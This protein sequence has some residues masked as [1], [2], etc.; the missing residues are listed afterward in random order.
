[1]RIIA[2]SAFES[3]GNIFVAGYSP[4]TWGSPLRAYT[5]NSDAFVVKLDSSGNLVWNTF[6]GGTGTDYG[7]RTIVDSSGNLFIAGQSS[8]SWGS[9]LRSFSG[10]SNGFACKITSSGSIV[11]NTFLGASNADCKGI[12]LDSSGNV[13][14]S[15]YSTAT[16]GSPVRA[17]T[18]SFDAFA[19]KLNSSGG[20][21]WNT[22]L[23]DQNV[24]Y[25][26]GIAV[27]SS[28]NVFIGGS[29]QGTWGNPVRPFAGGN[30][31]MVVK[32]DSSGNLTWNSYLGGSSGDFGY[33]IALD[34]NAIAF[35]SESVLLLGEV[36]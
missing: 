35:L 29:S 8:S 14:L 17:Y 5:S 33:D 15:G 22:F 2:R 1:M 21:L 34:T 30:D 19:C 4:T 25:G 28:G 31:A 24:D 11:W 23:G 26:Y 36:L 13:Y 18:G 20:L 12:A 27:D 7:Y 10:S 6:L 3:S 16:W 32:L 9:P